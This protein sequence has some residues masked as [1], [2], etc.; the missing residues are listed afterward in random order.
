MGWG[1]AI[2]LGLIVFLGYCF[3]FVCFLILGVIHKSRPLKLIGAIALAPVVAGILFI[4]GYLT[5]GS[6]HAKDPVWVFEKVFEIPPPR[7]VTGLKG[8]AFG[9][10]ALPPVFLR[11]NAPPEVIDMA[12]AD[13]LRPA[14]ESELSN[15]PLA[16]PPYW[17]HPLKA[18]PARLYLSGT[19]K[20][21]CPTCFGT[22]RL[23]YDPETQT[24]FFA[25]DHF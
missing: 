17:W 19:W 8:H 9:P 13:W 5:L 22:A 4:L 21:H 25:S 12:R 23:Y 2:L 1:V 16:G 7:G 11:F 15:V 14:E 10:F 24:A 6:H 20:Q 18:P 3:L